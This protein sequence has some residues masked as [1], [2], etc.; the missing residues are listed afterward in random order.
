M[1]RFIFRS[2]LLFLLM[3][4]LSS[5]REIRTI[6]M[7]KGRDKPEQAVLFTGKEN[8]KVT[9]PGRN[10]SPDVEIPRG[11]LNL[12]VLPKALPEGEELPEGVQ[13]VKIPEQWSRVILL[14]L[15]DPS[16]KVFPAHVLPVNA[17]SGKLPPGHTLFH[18]FTDSP[19]YGKFS[20][21]VVTVEPGKSAQMR[22]PIDEGGSYPV[23]INCRLP[24][25]DKTTAIVRSSWHHSSKSRKIVFIV[26]SAKGK[27][28]R[29][30]SL[31]DTPP[32]PASSD[33]S[34]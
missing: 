29:L 25:E 19:I 5:A 7:G 22:P 33:V 17:S 12:A 30:W 31:N 18:N 10:F 11:D 3:S 32:K 34:P 15:P 2:S 16:N 26:P 9:L 8:L 4:Q 27:I 13:I 21:T 23:E 6:F 28:P 1:F 14:F 24:G 20:K